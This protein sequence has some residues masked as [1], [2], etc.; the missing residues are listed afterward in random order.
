VLASF[1]AERDTAR[2]AYRRFVA[3][4]VD[5][6][7][8]WEALR[9][10]IWLGGRLFR[11]RMA[12]MVAAQDMEAVQSA[13]AQP[14]PP[15][16]SEVLAGVAEAFGI[17]ADAVLDRSLQPAFEAAVYLLRRVCNLPLAE[18]ARLAGVSPS[19]VSRIQ[20]E[21]ERGGPDAATGRRL[22]RY[23]VKH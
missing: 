8:P 17:D 18:T 21:L 3:A 12:Q 11:E 14:Q 10:Q 7:S 6:E 16:V 5:A 1:G 2:V 13:Q 23:K 20:A 15:A 9:G 19:R 4:G 22:D